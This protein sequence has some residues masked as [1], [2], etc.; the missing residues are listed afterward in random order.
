MGATATRM[1]A[2]EYDAVSVE[3]DRTQLVDGAIVVS[4][5]K[6]IH[7]VLQSRL[8]TALQ[9]WTD[10][11]PG[12]GLAMMPTS[13]TMDE[14]NVYGPDILWFSEA[15]RPRDLHRYPDR[16]PDLCVEIRSP[17]TWR[18]DIGT[19]MSV[20]ESGRL[21]EL[22]LV[23]D[24]GQTVLVFRRTHP[25]AATFDVSLELARGDRLESPQLPGFALELERL[26]AT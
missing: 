4:E 8:G 11:A 24:V 19:K 16:V 5:P 17:G 3:G 1:T 6:P 23:D 9:V 13:V 22:W 2:K 21:P 26:F 7:A 10:A 25:G 12:R 14:Y 18:Y 20:Y 15:H